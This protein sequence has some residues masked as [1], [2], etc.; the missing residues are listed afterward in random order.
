MHCVLYLHARRCV[1]RERARRIGY[2]FFVFPSPCTVLETASQYLLWLPWRRGPGRR[3][4]IF[5]F[6]IGPIGRQTRPLKKHSTTHHCHYQ[7]IPVKLCRFGCLQSGESDLS[8]IQ[9]QQLL[10]EA[11]QPNLCMRRQDSVPPPPPARGRKEGTHTWFCE[12]Q[13]VALI[14]QRVDRSGQNRL[15]YRH[16]HLYT[17][18]Q[19]S[20]QPD[21]G[22]LGHKR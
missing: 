16:M 20:G 15:Y 1:G 21:A 5:F 12:G 17:M 18:T 3:D 22:F 14:I 10:L 19:Y 2:S 7:D 6:H 11:R 8:L 13:E 9:G 4:L